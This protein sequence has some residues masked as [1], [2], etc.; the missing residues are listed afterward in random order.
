MLKDSDYVFAGSRETITNGLPIGVKIF[1]AA[2]RPLT[3]LEQGLI[4][5]HIDDIS[6]IIWKGH[7]L[8]DKEELERAAKIKEA[9]LGL[10]GERKIYTR[11]IPNGYCNGPCC[12]H[13]PWFLVTTSIGPIRIGWRKRVINIDWSETTQKKTA[14]ELFPDEDVTKDEHAIHAWGY[15]KAKEYLDKIHE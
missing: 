8:Q 12:I 1:I 15:D 13:L 2:G 9:I 7:T 14:D 11:E 3:E 10:F 5:N 4:Y 6:N